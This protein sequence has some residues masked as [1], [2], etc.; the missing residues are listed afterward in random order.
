MQKSLGVFYR[1]GRGVPQDDRL[2]EQWYHKA[3]ETGSALA[4]LK[5]R[6]VNQYAYEE[7]VA[8]HAEGKK[9]GSKLIL[10]LTVLDEDATQADHNQVDSDGSVRGYEVNYNHDV[11]GGSPYPY[12]LS[13]LN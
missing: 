11:R 2:A 1:Q 13:T 6:P 12:K 5:D 4:R 10:A 8:S 3:V 7:A 9:Q